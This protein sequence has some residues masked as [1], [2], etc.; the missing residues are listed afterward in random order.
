MEDYEDFEEIETLDESDETDMA[1]SFNDESVSSTMDTSSENLTDN[2]FEENE[3]DVAAK[4]KLNE[5]KDSNYQKANSGR[6]AYQK[7]LDN[8]KDYYN[9]K[10]NDIQN[11]K[12]KLNKD[13]EN[14]Q[15]KQDKSSER[16][17]R[18]KENHANQRGFSNKRESLKEL[19]ESRRDFKNTTKEKKEINNKEK[20][21]KRDEKNVNK[22]AK[23][24][25]R[26]KKLHPIEA[27]KMA[28]SKPLKILKMKIMLIIGGICLA[29][30]LIFFVIELILGP[31]EEAWGWIDSKITGVANFS[32]KVENFYNG[33][34]F[35]NS[36]EAFY[37]EIDDLY[38][39]YCPNVSNSSECPL[40]VPLLLSTIFYTEGMGY[41]TEYG[42]IEADGAV[43]GSMI[44]GSTNSGTFG[45]I[46]DYLRDKFD[47]SIETVSED[48]LVYNTG[49]IY[50]LRKLARNQF[51]T[52]FFGVA[53]REGEEIDISLKEFIDIYIDNISEDVGNL[54]GGIASSAI[55]TVSTPFKELYALIV[56]SDYSGSFIDDYGN[57][58]SD[59]FN[60]VAQ[61]IGDIFY[62][63][64]DITDIYLSGSSIRIKYRTFKFD[65]ENYKNYLINYYFEHMP[66]YKSMLGSLEGNARER[67]KESIYNDIVSNENLFRDIF[68]NHTSASS[69]AYVDSCVG[70][71]DNNLVSNLRKPIDIVEGTNINFTEDYAYGIKDGK[72]H[73]GVDLNE[74][75]T[76][77]K[78]GDNV[79]A[80]AKGKVREINLCQN[81]ND[82]VCS[83]G[84][85]II[86]DH[87]LVKDNNEY[88]F[89]SV[90][91]HL[92]RNSI[93]LKKNSTVEKDDIIGLIG[94]TASGYS[95]SYLHFEYRNNDGTENGTAIDPSNLFIPCQSSALLAGN[96][97]EEKIWNYLTGKGYPKASAAGIMGNMKTESGFESQIVQ[98]DT[99]MT[100]YSIDYTNNVDS[101]KISKSEFANNGPNGGGYG[102]V[103]WTYYTLKG[104]L[105]DFA[106]NEKKSSIGDLSMQLEY[107][108]RYLTTK[109]SSLYNIL[110]SSSTSYDT[111]ARRFMLDFERPADQ[112]ESAQSR[113]SNNAKEIYKRYA[114]Q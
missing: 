19:K 8:G 114:N 6:Q 9:N 62:G 25:D 47:E 85:Y 88:K 23:K 74:N 17:Q 57:I 32:E 2:K 72:L 86:I 83:D 24:A 16:L 91:K 53:T 107:L 30:F 78:E 10:K 40:N 73:N 104:D 28:I 110:Q 5:N 79:Y 46:R 84:A 64:A 3:T 99:P 89:I 22:D 59:G 34:G 31:L 77:S 90:Y 15:R 21:L 52:N 49:K 44:E 111:A 50:R 87:T 102:L 105:Y 38:N 76:G 26:F 48:G 75:T 7:K 45:A 97:N 71:I 36:K 96:T 103:Q 80:I 33:F 101:G 63:I 92:D 95:D 112:S 69:E 98:G 108:D 81:N 55:N 61:L 11:Q 27:T 106:K 94:G 56:G 35:Q 93:K 37:D 51:H 4:E 42:E 43:D 1:P 13:R 109:N 18:A 60:S 29:L 14:N 65:E 82:G 58:L 12:D 54:L 39:R 66:E 100:Q 67:K 70:A 41:D 68:L 20:G 113:R